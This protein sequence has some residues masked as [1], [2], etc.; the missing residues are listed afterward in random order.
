MTEKPNTPPKETTL[1][2]L[3]DALED[4]LTTPMGIGDMLHRQAHI[5][6]TMMHLV[7]RDAMDSARDKDRPMH[8]QERQINLAM[9]LQKQCVE[10]MKATAAMEYMSA[11]TPLPRRSPVHV[12]RQINKNNGLAPPTPH[13]PTERNE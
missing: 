13:F 8:F 3:C 6:D 7:V 4:A 2:D 10:T 1:P 12:T 9:R 5:L 11:I